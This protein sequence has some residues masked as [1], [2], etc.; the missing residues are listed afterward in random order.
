MAIHLIAAASHTA[1]QQLFPNAYPWASHRLYQPRITLLRCELDDDAERERALQKA[2]QR[3][4]DKARQS[5]WLDDAGSSLVDDDLAMLKE[6]IELQST[7]E[8]QVSEIKDMLRSM[9]GMVGVRF[10]E[11]DQVTAS[12]WVFVGL[13]VLV[14]IYAVN[15]LLVQPALSSA[16]AFS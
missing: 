16:A 3:R 15:M 12:A 14:F 1:M 13:N 11:N 9:E 5:E 7:T 8:Q 6:R 4:D 10:V 2:N